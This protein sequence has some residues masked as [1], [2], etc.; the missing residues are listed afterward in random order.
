MGQ[1]TGATKG[2]QGSE[3]HH[4]SLIMGGGA[5]NTPVPIGVNRGGEQRWATRLYKGR[6]PN[7]TTPPP[8][9]RGPGGRGGVKRQGGG[10]SQKGGSGRGAVDCTYAQHYISLLQLTGP[11]RGAP[12]RGGSH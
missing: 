5:T 7:P 6:A 2:G 11:R 3:G 8:Q 4:S 9:G 12:K 1:L 10:S